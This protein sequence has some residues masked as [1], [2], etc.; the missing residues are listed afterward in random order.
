[1]KLVKLKP[2]F[3]GDLMQRAMKVMEKAQ[4]NDKQLLAAWEKSGLNTKLDKKGGAHAVEGS[5]ADRAADL[6]AARVAYK[7]GKLKIKKN[8]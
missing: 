6:K 4:P 5:K 7:S 3:P 1:M 2:K 8:K